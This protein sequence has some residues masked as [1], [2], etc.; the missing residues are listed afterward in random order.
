MT[1]DYI[2]KEACPH[3]GSSDANALYTDGHHYC[4]SCET[5]TLPEGEE[6][7][8]VDDNFTTGHVLSLI[9]I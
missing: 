3:C 9:H 2:R 7:E 6:V 5:Y 4:F 8:Q 1:S